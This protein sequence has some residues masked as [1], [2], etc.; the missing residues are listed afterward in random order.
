MLCN[1][2]PSLCMLYDFPNSDY[3]QGLLE[4]V[5]NFLFLF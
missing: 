5:Q 1:F 4:F 3:Y 2:L